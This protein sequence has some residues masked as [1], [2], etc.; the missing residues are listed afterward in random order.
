MSTRIRFIRVPIE[1]GSHHSADNS[2]LCD[3]NTLKMW[4]AAP[5]HNKIQDMA[6]NIRIKY[7]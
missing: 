4:R 7:T 6:L 2:L 1:A 3:K 5:N